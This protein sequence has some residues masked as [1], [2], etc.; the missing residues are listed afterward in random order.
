MIPYGLINLYL[1]EQTLL[2]MKSRTLDEEKTIQ[3]INFSAVPSSLFQT[4]PR[5]IL[6]SSSVTS[7]LSDDYICYG[8]DHMLST[9]EFPLFPL[10]SRHPASSELL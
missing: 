7:K 3:P 5:I 10:V 2:N 1:R 4:K 9:S 6:V 8:A